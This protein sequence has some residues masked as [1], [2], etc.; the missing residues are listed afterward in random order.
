MIEAANGRDTS[1]VV[2]HS[3]PV[4]LSR[5][6]TFERDLH[7]TTDK[8]RLTP[9]FTRLCE[10][11]SNDLQRKGYLGR[12]VGI[13]LKYDN[14]KTVTRDQTIELP[15]NDSKE[16]RKFAGELL[17]RVDLSKKIRLL[18]VRMGSLVKLED[19]SVTQLSNTSDS[20]VGLN[21]ELF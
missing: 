10:Q 18:G 3:E 5:E 9:I 4:S 12:T 14:F 16:I 13:K 8:E 2:T 7:V 20:E 15:T 21:R 11:V 1:G 17:K 19:W 6:T